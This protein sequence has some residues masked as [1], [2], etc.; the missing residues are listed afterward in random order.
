[1]SKPFRF[2]GLDRASLGYTAEAYTES[3][4]VERETEDDG[5]T[6]DQRW[7]SRSC[8]IAL[9]YDK[10][11][12]IGTVL[13]CTVQATASVPEL[14]E[15]FALIFGLRLRKLELLQ[16]AVR[17]STNTE[18]ADKDTKY[19]SIFCIQLVVPVCRYGANDSAEKI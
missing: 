17:L 1:M 14:H 6:L 4:T 3:P 19:V 5:A 2:H 9:R 13:Y 12:T 10:I 15:L 8:L 11:M 16:L 18:M 7:Y